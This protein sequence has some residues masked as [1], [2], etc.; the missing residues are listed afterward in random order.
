VK[1][2]NLWDIQVLLYVTITAAVTLIMLVLLAII[3][4]RVRVMVSELDSLRR[5]CKLLEEGVRAVDDSLRGRGVREPRVSEVLGPT[6]TQQPEL[7]AAP[8]SSK[9]DGPGD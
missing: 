1:L 5:E 3:S 4:R 7:P 8:T 6:P 2:S 9:A